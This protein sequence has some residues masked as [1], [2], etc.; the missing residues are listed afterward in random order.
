MKVLSAVL[1]SYN[2]NT[3]DSHVGD[4]VKRSLSVAFRLDYDAVSAELNRI[5]RDLGATAYNSTRVFNKF[6]SQRGYA[7]WNT[8]PACTRPTVN[9]FADTHTQ[10]TWLLLSG[11]GRSAQIQGATDHMVCVVDGTVYDSWDSLNEIV[12][13]SMMITNVLSEPDNDA[14][15]SVV[16]PDIESELTRYVQKLSDQCAPYLE[17]QYDPDS[18]EF[19]NK[20][21]QEIYVYGRILQGM[22]QWDWGHDQKYYYSGEVI[23]HKLVLKYNPRLDEDTNTDL[24][25]KKCKQK[26]YDW[27]YM[28]RKTLKDYH[29]AK[30]IMRNSQYHGSMS[31]LMTF[32]EWVRPRV[33]SYRDDGNPDYEDKFKMYIEALPDD[34]RAK[35][36]PEVRF[37][38]DTLRELKGQL[39]DY[40]DRYLRLDYDY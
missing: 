22:T 32:P 23:R 16:L 14:T 3:R 33:V 4:C 5:K 11:H 2:A 13:H 9:E 37:A 31:K 1:K 38:A 30:S 24:L 40:H 39:E 12:V 28:I 17:L 34:P 36:S 29:D 21:T 35:S 7:A 15:L 20:Y 18:R 19:V 26:T 25:I 10:G 8:I 27:A 6:L